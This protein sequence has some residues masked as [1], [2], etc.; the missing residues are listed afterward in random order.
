M[1]SSMTLSVYQSENNK[2]DEDDSDSDDK[3]MMFSAVYEF[4]IYNELPNDI[5]IHGETDD[6]NFSVSVDPGNAKRIFTLPGTMLTYDYE[7]A[8]YK[9]P[10][11]K[12]VGF[13]VISKQSD[14][15]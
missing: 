14:I 10:T 6:A 3:G 5:E 7:G 9:I 4:L 11:S 12:E 1:G 15:R 13:L 8:N 2:V